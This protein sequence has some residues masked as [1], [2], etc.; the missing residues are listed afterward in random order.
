MI[1]TFHVCYFANSDETLYITGSSPLLGEWDKR[2]ALPMHKYGIDEWQVSIESEEKTLLLDYKYMVVRADGLIREE[3]G[4]QHRI[5]LSF[6]VG[7]CAIFDRWQDLQPT[8]PFFSSPFQSVFFKRKAAPK[9]L[10]VST[11]KHLVIQLYAPLVKPNESV[12]LVG[13][14]DKLG[15]WDPQKGIPLDDS[16]FP[17]WRLVTN[18]T[19]VAYGD[20]YKFVIIDTKT[21]QTVR[22]E[23]GENRVAAITPSRHKPITATII[24]DLHFKQTRFDWK[25][26]G[27]A[28]PI[29]SLRSDSSWGI[30]DF[31]D[32]PLLVNWACQTGMKV[33]QLLPINDTT[34]MHSWRD[35]YPYNANSCYALHPLYLNPLK[36]GVLDDLLQMDSYRQKAAELN[37]SQG[38][39]YEA[40][41]ALKWSYFRE[42]FA[43][44]GEATLQSEEYLRFYQQEKE[45]LQPY[46]SF[47]FLREKYQTA[48]FSRW[49]IYC[50]Y[51]PLKIQ[52]LFS[53]DSP[54]Y[55]EVALHLFLQYHLHLQLSEASSYAHQQGVIFKGDIPIGISRNSVEAWVEPDLFHMECQAGAPPDDF[56]VN[57]QNWGFPTYNWP[58]MHTNDLLWWKKRFQKMNDYFDA[59]R[60]DHILGF[61]RIWEIPNDSVEGL[62]GYFNP[63]LPF[64][65]KEIEAFGF[66]FNRSQTR[67]YIRRWYLTNLFGEQVAE[68][69]SS[70]L[71][72]NE[73]G[74]YSLKEEYNTQRKLQTHFLRSDSEDQIFV[75]NG[76]YSLTN[77]VL[78]VEDPYRKDHYHPRI[79]AYQT[80]AYHALSDQ[81]KAAFDNLYNNFYFERHNHFWQERA[82]EKL[83]QLMFATPMLTCAEDLGMIPACVSHVMETLQAL[84]LEI[85]RMPKRAFERFGEIANYPYLS[86]CTTSTHDMSTLRQWWQEERCAVQLY[87]NNQLRREGEAPMECTPEICK[88]IVRLHLD[89]P[90]LLTILPLQDI[91]AI[92]SGLR[93]SDVASERI[94]VPANPNHCWN[95]RMHLSLETL[96]ASA[97]FNRALKT[98]ITN[99]KR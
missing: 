23:E 61:F 47:C 33:V 31:G 96:N 98:M 41:D 95:Y 72:R 78:F 48:D 74:S 91:L 63:A 73:G 11:Q 40:V 19:T 92:D 1:I 37:E 57:G 66:D 43:Q 79:A 27:V 20:E 54:F 65:Q 85:Q 84:T 25:A 4:V 89:A 5:N 77:Q 28:L 15:N 7:S 46:A 30:G 93:N 3:W 60:I 45:W 29:F 88:Q 12:V 90:S 9:T 39:D 81:Q 17:L 64:A 70:Y 8:H 59:Y 82:F 51:D 86:V 2:S 80:F 97:A 75:R 53:A 56:S 24:S 52:P 67:P 68:V 36:I 76:L 94:N 34:M 69:I 38:V 87:Y 16:M 49:E 32:L 99:S 21:G 62:L 26:A 83:P 71:V 14:G 10:K 6:A 13:D 18:P 50:N 22:W 58:Q 42:I 55:Q 44:E 35:S